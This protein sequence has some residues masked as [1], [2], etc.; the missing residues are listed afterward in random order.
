MK[1]DGKGVG[2]KEGTEARW[3]CFSL[4]ISQILPLRV[5]NCHDHRSGNTAFAHL[6]ILALIHLFVCIHAHF[7]VRVPVWMFWLSQV[8]VY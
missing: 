1:S 8:Y 4:N 2:W 3:C 5:C 6:Y 7:S